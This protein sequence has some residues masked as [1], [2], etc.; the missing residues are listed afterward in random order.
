MHMRVHDVWPKFIEDAM[1]ATVR[2]P[3]ESGSFAE[4]PGL[5]PSRLE[6][7]LQVRAVTAAVRDDGRFEAVPVQTED[8]V[9]GHSFG[10]ASAAE[11]GENMKDALFHKV[12]W[13]Q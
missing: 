7:T 1:Q 5:D 12:P 10:A 2:P 3:A 13:N 4:E 6:L 9:N 8:D 11:I